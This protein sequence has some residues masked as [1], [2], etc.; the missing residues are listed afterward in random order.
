[1]VD[2][3]RRRHEHNPSLKA[4]WTNLREQHFIV[5]SI[6]IFAGPFITGCTQQRAQANM[7]SF[8]ESPRRSRRI[9]SLAGRQ[10]ALDPASLREKSRPDCRNGSIEG[11]AEIYHRQQHQ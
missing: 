3:V 8:L 10:H 6:V 11:V 7:C 2:L 5:V 1:M 4:L 9:H